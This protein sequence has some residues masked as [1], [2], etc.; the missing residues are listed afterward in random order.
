MILFNIDNSQMVQ[1]LT[2]IY[3][4]NECSSKRA[5]PRT[6]SMLITR[7]EIILAVHSHT[8]QL[9]VAVGRRFPPVYACAHVFSFPN[10]QLLGT[11]LAPTFEFR[12]Y[13][14]EVKLVGHVGGSI[15][16]WEQATVAKTRS[17]PDNLCLTVFS[18]KFAGL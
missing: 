17:V 10:D 7:A 1:V 3:T 2:V 12:R 16:V 11:R 18:T 15:K 6:L 5:D 8:N 9:S 13:D 4:Q 14:A